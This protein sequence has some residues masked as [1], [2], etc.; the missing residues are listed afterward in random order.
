MDEFFPVQC[1]DTLR[2]IALQVKQARL[3]QA[4]RQV[5]ISERL[6]VS[7][8]AYRLIEKGEPGVSLRDFMLV[9]WNLGLSDRIF[10]SLKEDPSFSTSLEQE[11]ASRRV[12]L[13]KSSPENF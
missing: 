9:L 7:L 3:Q 1:A 2:R 6:G 11:T 13:A 10:Q 5:D 12:R 4:I 8:R